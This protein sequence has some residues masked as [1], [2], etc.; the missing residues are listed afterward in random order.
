MLDRGI[1]SV[2][3]K[4]SLLMVV[5]VLLGVLVGQVVVM[6]FIPPPAPSLSPQEVSNMFIE[7]RDA[8]RLG[9]VLCML[10]WSCWPPFAMT[11]S[12]LMRRMEGRYPILT[13]ISIMIMGGGYPFFVAIP[14]IWGV[15]SFRPEVFDPTTMQMMNDFAW[16]CYLF[17]WPPFTLWLVVVGIAML[18]DRNVPTLYPR[19]VAYLTFWVAISLAPA[20]LIVF[21][22]TGIFAYDGL[23]AFYYPMVLWCGWLVAM[24]PLTFKVI[25]RLKT[26]PLHDDVPVAAVKV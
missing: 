12:T 21:F 15:M 9:S 14:L 26:E 13:Y 25:N 3:M 11:F 1:D 8:L 2:V 16:F 4:V 23:I 10:A 22:E 19:W 5:P 18:R 7:R 20:G 17:V 6:G 24:I